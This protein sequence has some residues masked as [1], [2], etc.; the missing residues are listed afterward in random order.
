MKKVMNFSSLLADVELP[1]VTDNSVLV[2][3]FACTYGQVILRAI[4]NRIIVPEAVAGE[5]NR[6]P[7]QTLFLNELSEEGVLEIVDLSEEESEIF[8][9]LT[10]VEPSL[11]DGE[12]A[13]IAISINRNFLPI[14]D[15]RKGRKRATNLVT[16]L[17]AGLSLDLLR[18]PAAIAQLGSP[19]DVDA[20]YRA[21]CIFA[22]YCAGQSHRMQPANRMV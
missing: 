6:K 7:E 17:E 16:D 5:F 20:L 13:T 9:E 2:N 18:H 10:S 14:I 3:I 12:A 4:P 21:L 1:M 19:N 11:D 8:R 15:E 22:S